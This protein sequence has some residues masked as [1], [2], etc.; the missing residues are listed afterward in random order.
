MGFGMGIA[1]T[2]RPPNQDPARLNLTQALDP[3]WGFPTMRGPTDKDSSVFG[4]IL[5]P[6]LGEI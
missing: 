6:L 2:C 3:K 1:G 4:F 5:G